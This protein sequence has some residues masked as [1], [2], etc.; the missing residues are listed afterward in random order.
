MLLTACG[1]GSPDR[2]NATR[3]LSGGIETFG[4]RVT[5]ATVLGTSIP[6]SGDAAPGVHPDP[7]ELVTV[8]RV[9]EPAAVARSAGGRL[10]A[11]AGFG[12]LSV[13]LSIHDLGPTAYRGNPGQET[14]LISE[15]TG[16]HFGRRLGGV[17]GPGLC[18]TNLMRAIALAAGQTVRGCLFFEVPVTQ[19]VSA[20]Q[21]QTQG[22]IGENIA[23]WAVNRSAVHG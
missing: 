4:S 3:N 15:N 6:F 9:I 8:V 22:G 14:S 19:R 17:A 20:V 18:A 11:K 13:E 1:S 23:T 16:G 21:Y 12:Y 7:R 10:R 2:Q 5:E